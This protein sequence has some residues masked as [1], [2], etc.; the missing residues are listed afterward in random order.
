ML[1]RQ[2]FDR[3]SDDQKFEHLYQMCVAAE[4]AGEAMAATLAILRK[5][6]EAIESKRPGTAS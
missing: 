5:R 2:K 1:T 3:L 6:L 4:R